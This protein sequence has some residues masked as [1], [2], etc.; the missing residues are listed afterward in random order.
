MASLIT[1]GTGLVGAELAHLLVERGEEVVVCNRTLRHD[2]IE[3]IK[4]RVT[5]VSADVSIAAH[6]F[7]LVRDY[8][9]TDI[10]HIGAML[11][12]VSEANPW[13]SFQSNVVGTYNVLEA[14]RLFGVKRMMYSSSIAVF[15]LGIAE[16]VTDTTLQRPVAIYG[17]GKLYCEGLG[18]F[19]RSKFGLDFSTIR[20]PAVVGPGVKTPGH[21]VPPMLDDVLAGKPHKCLVTEDTRTWMMS[22]RDAARAA[23]LVLHAPAE[24]KK[25]VNYNVSGP[26]PAIAAGEIAAAIKKYIPEAVIEFRKTPA[27]GAHKGHQGVFDDSYAKQEWGWQAEHP[28]VASIVGDYIKRVRAEK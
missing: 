1:G 12:A 27:K 14:A 4:D 2:R 7:N 11:S 18:R 24:K 22:L 8:K 19:Y 26:N 21:W 5:A 16:K 20:Y 23:Y 6:V 10:Y 17:V 25:M 13:G 9:I 3:D 15:G 28:D